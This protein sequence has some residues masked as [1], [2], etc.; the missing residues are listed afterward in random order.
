MAITQEIHLTQDSYKLPPVVHAVQNDTGRTLKMIIDDE[1]LGGSDTGELCFLRPDGSAYNA[2]ATLVLADNAFT[3]AATQGCTQSGATKCQLKVTSSSKVV[4]SYTFLLMVQ[5]DVYGL[6]PV[7]QQGYD[8]DDLIAAAS[9]IDLSAVPK[10]V[11]Y[12][13]NT[14]L[15]SQTLNTICRLYQQV[16]ITDLP[17][18][19]DISTHI[20][21][22]WTVG[23]SSNKHQVLWVPYQNGFYQRIYRNSSWSD[24]SGL[25]DTNTLTVA[26]Y[27]GGTVLGNQTLNRIVRVYG[28]SGIT[29]APDGVDLE[30]YP[31]WLWTYGV[32]NKHQI[33][34]YPH[35]AAAYQR[36][37]RQ[38]SGTWGWSAWTSI[39]SGG[40]SS[41]EIKVLCVGNSFNQ[42]VMAYVPVIL[43]EILP[44]T[45]FTFG[46]LYVGSASYQKHL[47]MYDNSTDYTYWNIWKPGA[48]MWLRYKDTGGNSKTL[49]EGL[50]YTD[51]DII[52][53]QDTSESVVED[54]LPS[55]I[56]HGRQLMRVIQENLT[57]PAQMITWAFVGRPYTSEGGTSYSAA[58][59]TDYVMDATD[60]VMQNMGFKD[61]FPIANAIGSARTN[62]TFA[63]L[64]QAGNLLFDNHLQNGIGDLISAYVIAL[65]ILEW[66]GHGQ[67]GIYGS[68]FVPTDANIDAINADGMTHGTAVG[69]DDPENILAAQEIATLAVRNPTE[70]ID[71]SDIIV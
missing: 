36:I 5:P 47:D 32:T 15:G 12:D 35:M 38:V 49:V 29:D 7:S 30:T 71:C 65:K 51:W 14:S 21:W 6:D 33:L 19:V 37:Y 13:G 1:T 3:C 8:I 18:G 20:C 56:T 11:S 64:G 45:R 25:N 4:S 39:G 59:M 48:S 58:Q 22:L 52:T 55:S 69:I 70:I 60:T 43:Q 9:T 62:D 50:Q 53:M 16:G 31:G 61:F 57:A 54:N 42:D 67:K 10:V 28:V 41:D 24:W 26:S 63:A 34:F 2:T 46:I 27:D 23:T 44:N 17:S 40:G 68:T 66:T